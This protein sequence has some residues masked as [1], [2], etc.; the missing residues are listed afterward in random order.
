MVTGMFDA[1]EDASGGGNDQTVVVQRCAG[2][3]SPA[4]PPRGPPPAALGEQLLFCSV[5]CSVSL[6][7]GLVDE[8]ASI[9]MECEDP[10]LV[11]LEDEKDVAPA[12]DL[13]PPRPRRLRRAELRFRRLVLFVLGPLPALG[14]E[15]SV[16]IP[17]AAG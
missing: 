7:A 11:L 13:P 12:A 2:C 3:L 16:A 15:E 9:D 4:V 6:T 17:G 10:E 5:Y 1:D 14:Q 8:E